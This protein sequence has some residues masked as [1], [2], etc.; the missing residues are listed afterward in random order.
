[1]EYTARH[2]SEQRLI[3]E[4][5]PVMGFVTD[6]RCCQVPTAPD[7]N[8]TE[9]DGMRNALKCLPSHKPFGWPETLRRESVDQPLS[10]IYRPSSNMRTLLLSVYDREGIILRSCFTNQLWPSV[11]DVNKGRG[12]SSSPILPACATCARC[13]AGLSRQ[14]R[15][16]DTQPH[17]PRARGHFRVGFLGV[18]GYGFFRNSCP[19]GTR[20][21]W[22]VVICGASLASRLVG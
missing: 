2:A 10:F 4:W 17:E 3:G 19:V 18:V 20:Q 11:G 7:S 13:S 22:Q 15:D 5:R 8:P 14:N 16:H 12:L 6:L 1:M 9:G 21:P